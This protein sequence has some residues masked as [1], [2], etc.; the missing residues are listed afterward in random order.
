MKPFEIIIDNNAGLIPSKHIA[1][2]NGAEVLSRFTVTETKIHVL[3]KP[4]PPALSCSSHPTILEVQ[5]EGQAGVDKHCKLFFGKNVI[6]WGNG[7]ALYFRGKGY[8]FVKALY[9]ADGMQLEIADFEDLAQVPQ[10][11][12]CGA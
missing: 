12:M 6:T 2:W 8:L 1:Q 5:K 9:E 3:F 4:P 10:L 11:A 7:Q